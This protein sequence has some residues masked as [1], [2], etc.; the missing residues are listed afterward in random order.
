MNGFLKIKDN[1]TNLLNLNS[2]IQSENLWILKQGVA[3]GKI[4]INLGTKHSIDRKTQIRS[5]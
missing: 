3:D 2:T 5:F 4:N 1:Y